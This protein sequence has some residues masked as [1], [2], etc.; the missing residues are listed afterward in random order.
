MRKPRITWTHL[1]AVSIS[2]YSY[3]AQADLES[4]FQ[5]SGR[6]SGGNADHPE[7]EKGGD[8]CKGGFAKGAFFAKLAAG[9]IHGCVGPELFAGEAGLDCGGFVAQFYILVASLVER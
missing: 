1:R 4:L 5:N 7:E 2:A 3:A 9:L 8:H 6:F